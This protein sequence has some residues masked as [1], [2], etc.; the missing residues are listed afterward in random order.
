MAQHRYRS[1][2]GQLRCLLVRETLGL[3]T[4]WRFLKITLPFLWFFLRIISIWEGDYQDRDLK[5][6]I[7]LCR[8]LVQSTKS[9]EKLL[10]LKS[11]LLTFLISD[12]FI[13]FLQDPRALCSGGRLPLLCAQSSGSA[14]GRAAYRKQNLLLWYNRCVF[15]SST[16]WTRLSDFWLKQNLFPVIGRCLLES[17]KGH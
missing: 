17:E 3:E 1:L 13:I 14:E 15:G 4:L 5:L 10:L 16:R 9:M 6:M 11:N 2:P 8:T 7:T 12:F